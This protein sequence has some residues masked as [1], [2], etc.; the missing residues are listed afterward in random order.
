MNDAERAGGVDVLCLLTELG[1]LSRRYGLS[2]HELIAWCG[3]FGAW[4]LVAGP[5]HQ[6][7]LELSDERYDE[8]QMEQLRRDTPSHRVSRWWWL[9]PPVWYSKQRRRAQQHRRDA[10][11]LRRRY[12]DTHRAVPPSHDES[13]DRRPAMT[14]LR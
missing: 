2:M 1:V 11:D 6:A 10:G 4:L 13:G 8:E 14:D 3:F 5:F 12:G 9:I 7:A